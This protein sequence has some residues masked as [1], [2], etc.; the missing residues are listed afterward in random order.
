MF[1]AAPDEW[2]QTTFGA[3]CL[4]K[5]EYGA[6]V[7]KRDFDPEL[8]RYVR[9]TDIGRG[10]RLL[11]DSLVSISLADAAD[12]MLAD[13]DL[14][15]AR[16]GATVGKSFLYDGS[17]GACAFAGYLIR[18]RPDPKQ[19]DPYFARLCVDTSSYWSWVQ[20]V[21]RAGAQPNIN[22][23]EFAA[24]PILL[25]PLAEQQ[26]IAEVVRAADDTLNLSEQ[27]VSQVE[28]VRQAAFA[29]IFDEVGRSHLSESRASEGWRRVRL[30][31]V[32]TE[33]REGGRPGLPVASISI[34]AGLVLR[35][36]LDRRVE[37]DLSE[38]AHALVKVGDIA[39]NTMRMWQGA[40][41]L[42]TTECCVS[43][44]YVVMTPQVAM[45]PEFALLALRSPPVIRLLHAY[46]QGV[47]DDR[48]RLYPGAFFQISINLP[49]ARVQAELIEHSAA[50]DE[51]LMGTR[52]VQAGLATGRTMLVSDL[53]S[54]RVRVP[55]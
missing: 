23:K 28:K 54:G 38:E 15:L 27:S 1:D 55:A 49:P 19:I 37:S 4:G 30:G 48:L 9:I 35:S 36:S 8:P 53:F 34:E 12:Y 7:P 52:R 6:N 44:A 5:G 2:A 50:F 13:G 51:N 18:F 24:Y 40:C 16:S 47:V 26:R 41:G 46:S 17:Y 22:A 25:P 3:V 11:S 42:A 10:G 33:R 14:L 43:P 29:E 45:L 32:F 21:N 31:E 20:S 39:Y